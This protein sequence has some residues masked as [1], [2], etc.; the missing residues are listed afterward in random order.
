VGDLKIYL[1]ANQVNPAE[2]VYTATVY[3]FVT[4]Q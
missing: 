3:C 2:G 4:P 1:P